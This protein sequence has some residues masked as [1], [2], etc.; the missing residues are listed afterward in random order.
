MPTWELIHSIHR[1]S[2]QE[3]TDESLTS[4]WDSIRPGFESEPI[5][6]AVD[7][8]L[9]MLGTRLFVPTPADDAANDVLDALGTKVLAPAVRELVRP[10][11]R[12]DVMRELNA[13][14]LADVLSKS[15][16]DA[17]SESDLQG[18][19]ALMD[20]LL[21]RDVGSRRAPDSE[22]RLAGT[23]SAPSVGGALRPWSDLRKSDAAGATTLA[24]YLEL[25]DRRRLGERTRLTELTPYARATD[26]LAALEQTARIEDPIAL[27]RW[28]H[29]RWD[30]LRN[31]AA[32]RARLRALPI[33]PTRR[34]TAR[35]FVPLDDLALAESHGRAFVD[36][37]GIAKVLDIAA[38]DEVRKLAELL[39]I[40]HLSL[41]QYVQQQLPRALR[42]AEAPVPHWIDALLRTLVRHHDEVVDDRDMSRTLAELEFV[43]CGSACFRP[44]DA[45]FASFEVDRILGPDWPTYSGPI[46]A[47]RLL[48]DLGVSD[49]PQSDQVR[50]RVLDLAAKPPDD[51]AVEVIHA[52]I[53]LIA[54]E[55]A[56]EP[57]TT[58]AIR[59]A[60]LE[61][62]YFDL[63]TE[64]WLPAV[65]DRSRWYA[66]GEIYRT[67]RRHIFSSQAIFLDVP[68][69]LRDRAN[70]VLEAFGV[71]VEPSAEMVVAHLRHCSK[72]Q[73]RAHP[74]VYR[75]LN[76]ELEDPAIEQLKE[77]ACLRLD[78]GSWIRP[79]AAFWDEHGLGQLATRL[80]SHD[81]SQWRPLLD[82]IGVRAAPDADDA[83]RVL[84]TI[85][86]LD[87]DVALRTSVVAY[88]WR[89]LETALEAAAIAPG[90]V[91][92]KL[93]N[94]RCV[95]AADG[96]LLRPPEVFADDRPQ[97]S[98]RLR[99]H[100]GPTLIT[101]PSASWQALQ[102]AGVT[103]IS[104]HLLAD[105]QYA[106]SAPHGTIGASSESSV[107]RSLGSWRAGSAA[108][109]WSRRC[110]VL[111]SSSCRARTGCR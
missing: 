66:P 9:D 67:P 109:T 91:R 100:L 102:A 19:W 75:K 42:E 93:G 70:A 39:D 97:L 56:A 101:R 49:T 68:A 92:S 31:D 96:T 8:T 21:T 34:E 103:P 41:R 18:L 50:E 72:E 84:G 15:A 32:P 16:V 5:T 57:P 26:V 37:A 55:D 43:P 53:G 107:R 63:F 2:A 6:P 4:L 11:P 71:E 13:V 81:W 87:L 90:E 108:P 33:F 17:L 45:L 12:S 105:V 78:D 106:S 61:E 25:L 46:E 40:K 58:R 44:G 27:I 14:S 64:A 83:F 79:E 48:A 28:F 52:V 104:D 60:R 98:G 7:G 62:D 80:S 110:D 38:G 77:F 59:R 1:T 36:D 47:R 88:C 73:L 111:M 86:D 20:R 76:D 22:R 23:P 29:G 99:E 94:S 3:P 10:L 82:A 69:S 54:D 24:P 74:D 89:L 65:D 95:E 30:E 85:A 51:A 35:A